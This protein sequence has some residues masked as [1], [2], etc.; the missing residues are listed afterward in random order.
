M[1]ISKVTYGGNTLM[2]L[3][4]DT[5]T[6]AS[7]LSGYTAHGADGEPILGAANPSSGV[8]SWNGRTGSVM[9]LSG[10]YDDSQVV[11]SS[12]MHIGGETQTNVA[13]ALSALANNS[14]GQIIINN[15]ITGQQVP[16]SKITISTSDPADDYVFDEGEIWLTYGDVTS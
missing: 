5:V 2:D 9:P 4:N 13:E 12:V 10:D 11:L 1:A 15:L 16:L 8:E 3:T 7:L 6:S 14:S